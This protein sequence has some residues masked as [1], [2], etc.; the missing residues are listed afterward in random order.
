MRQNHAVTLSPNSFDERP[1]TFKIG[2]REF[3]LAVSLVERAGFGPN[4]IGGIAPRDVVPFTQHLRRVLDAGQVEEPDR[5][6]LEGLVDYM[7]KDG[8]RNRGLS[9]SR[10]WK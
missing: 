4:V 2:D 5:Q 1:K 9:I 3:R 8:G 6:V 10:V 7:T